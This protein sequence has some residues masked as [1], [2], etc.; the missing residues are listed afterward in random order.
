MIRYSYNPDA[1]VATFDDAAVRQVPFGMA[2]ALN[3]M[4]NEAQAAQRSGMMDRFNIRRADWNMRAIK[5]D[6][7]DRATKTS[8]RVIMQVDPRAFHLD[9]FEEEG[10]H[11]PFNG[12]HYLW[13]PNE[14][15]FKNRII[16]ADDLLYPKKLQLGHVQGPKTKGSKSEGYAIRGLQ[17]TFMI[18]TANGPIVLQRTGSASSRPLLS[19]STKRL[20]KLS[21]DNYGSSA[22]YRIRRWKKNTEDTTRKL[23]QLKER[24]TVPLK[25][26]FFPTIQNTVQARGEI[27]FRKSMDMALSSA[28]RR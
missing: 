19:E 20:N 28:R 10:I 15:V 12:R 26:E 25:L 17:R 2:R 7:A 14:A 24:V 18:K 16:R 3:W 1:I 22:R 9:K 4:A 21:L 5:I 11:E 13:V 8:W 6:K 23:Y 27:L